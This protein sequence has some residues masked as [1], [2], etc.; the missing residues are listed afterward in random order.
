M[1]RM[2]F[3]LVVMATMTS[4][5]AFSQSPT[6][7]G[8]QPPPET[9]EKFRIGIAG[10]TFLKFDIDKAL[11]TMQKVDVHYLC[12]KDF[13]LPM[14]STDEQIAAFHAKLKEKGGFT[15]EISKALSWD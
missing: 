1:K 14:T 5:S 12:I 15:P 13:H 7:P 10:F 4:L 6:R 3:L 9:G 11:E 8:P 2:L